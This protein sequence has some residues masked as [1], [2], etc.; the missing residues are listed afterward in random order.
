VYGAP[1]NPHQDVVDRHPELVLH[2]LDLYMHVETP[3]NGPTVSEWRGL[4][5]QAALMINGG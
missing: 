5:S 1:E 2:L 4:G 3:Q